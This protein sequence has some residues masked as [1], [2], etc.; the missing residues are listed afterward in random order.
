MKYWFTA[1]PHFGC[2]N[3]IRNTRPVFSSTEEHDGNLL[4]NYNSVGSKGDVLVIIG[5]FCKKDPAEYRNR[6]KG[7]SQIFFILGNHDKEA[8]IRE[9]FGRNVWHRKFVRT[10]A[11]IDVLCTHPP[12]AFW[13]K[14]HYA[15]YSA[16]GH[17]HNCHKREAMLDRGFPGRRSMDVGVDSAFAKLGAY[18]PFSE[19]EFFGFLADREGHDN[20]DKSDRWP[21][22][23]F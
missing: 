4:E 22:R 9:A 12:E 17:I 3:L 15:V 6:I 14:S 19:D 1:D 11:G 21:D 10:G 7:F 23:D 8:K 13:Y 16:Y 18:R 5:D 20:I 2:H